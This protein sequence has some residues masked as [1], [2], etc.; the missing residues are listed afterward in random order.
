MKPNLMSTQNMVLVPGKTPLPWEVAHV[1]HGAI[2]HHFYQSALIGDERDFYVYTPPGYDARSSKKYPVLYLLHG[3]SDDASGW[4]SV[5]RAHVIMDNMIAAGKVKPMIIVMPLGYGAPEIVQPGGFN[6]RD[7]DIGKRNFD[8]FSQAL[9]GEVMPQI[10]SGYRVK[11]DR[12]S[13]AIVGLSMGG[14]ESLT[15]GINHLEKFGYVGSFS[16]AAIMAGNDYSKL[17][18]MLSAKDN[19]RLKLLWIGCGKD[20]FLIDSNHSLRDWLKAKGVHASY[21]ETP[22]AH[23]WLVWRR[24]LGEFAPLLFQ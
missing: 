16:G 18:P 22:G 13:R 19:S 23:T 7:P 10:E 4:T 21:V 3:Y 6:R 1:P 24:Y 14:G 11:S 2:Q 17:F 15:T 8:R 20:D 12:N 9:L 5:G